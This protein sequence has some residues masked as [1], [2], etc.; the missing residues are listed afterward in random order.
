MRQEKN[1]IEEKQAELWNELMG[2]NQVDTLLAID[3]LTHL[4]VEHQK[5]DGAF[6]NQEWDII[7][8]VMRLLVAVSRAEYEGVIKK[9]GR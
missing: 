1:Q 6:D 5:R 7:Y 8:R 3:L 9:L 4:V 2:L